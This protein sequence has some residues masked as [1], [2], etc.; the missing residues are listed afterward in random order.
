MNKLMI[1]LGLLLIAGLSFAW[2]P[3]TSWQYE[4]Q[5][6]VSWRYDC[7]YGYVAAGQYSLAE[8]MYA[9]AQPYV[10]YSQLYDMASY[11]DGMN[12]HLFDSGTAGMA[13]DYYATPF[14]ADMAG[15]NSD[16]AAFKTI[17]NAVLRTYL[18][19]GGSS[20]HVMGMLNGFNTNYR[21]CIA[22]D[23][24]PSGPR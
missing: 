1:V 17:F 14:R 21:E 10:A 18:Q 2:L 12:Y 23:P 22:D 3:P 15:Y 8:Y 20:S 19:H 24:W 9:Y 5:K 6:Y 7:Q 16:N 4:W 11:L 13:Y